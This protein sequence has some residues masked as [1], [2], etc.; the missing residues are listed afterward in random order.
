L[1]TV[2]LHEI[3][4]SALP[5]KPGISPLDTFRELTHHEITEITQAVSGVLENILIEKVARMR[6]SWEVAKAKE[7][8]DGQSNSKFLV[9]ELKAGGIQDYHFGLSGRVGAETLYDAFKDSFLC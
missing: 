2:P 1:Q 6:E 9:V 4:S 7:I 3:I 8:H 5:R